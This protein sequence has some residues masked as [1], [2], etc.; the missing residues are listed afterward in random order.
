MSTSTKT[1]VAADPPPS[2][3]ILDSDVIYVVIKRLERVA[4][5]MVSGRYGS[6]LDGHLG[7]VAELLEWL[8][9]SMRARQDGADQ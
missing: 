8:S 6:E 5:L 9:L 7:A 4:D 1:A 2:P 3:A